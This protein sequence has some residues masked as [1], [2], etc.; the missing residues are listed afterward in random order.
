MKRGFSSI[1]LVSTLPL[2]GCGK[3][4]PVG[5]TPRDCT[6]YGTVAAEDCPGMCSVSNEGFCGADALQPNCDALSPSAAIDVCGVGTPAPEQGGELLA[7]ERSA[8]VM[9]FGGSGPPDLSCLSPDGFPEPP[10]TPET[11]ALEGIVEVFSNGCQSNN[12]EIEVFTVVRDGSANDGMPGDL[13]GTMVVTPDDCTIDGVPEENEDCIDPQL[14][15]QRFECRYSYPGVPSETELLVLTKGE[16]WSELYEYNV[17]A[18]NAEVQ[19]GVYQKDIRA[20]ASD[21]Y[22][23]IPQVA[24][25]GYIRPGNGAIGGEVHDCGNVRLVNAVVDVDQNAI[26]AGR[27]LTYFTDDEVKP[28]PASGARAT[29]TL[30]LYAAMDIPDGP[31]GV[32]ATGAIDGKVVGVGF[33]R[34]RIFPNAVTSVTFRGLRPFQLP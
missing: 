18:A 31:V 11:I 16:G 4:D 13:V 17:Y 14:N 19:D 20:L 12:V 22:T 3:S 29:S 30:G 34:A 10:G 6:K 1:L 27:I 28:L 26:A 21:D 7:L 23:T 8:N 15:N 9:K 5:R 24:Y 25:G 32:A 2:L 33:F